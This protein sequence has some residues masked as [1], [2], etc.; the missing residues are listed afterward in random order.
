MLKDYATGRGRNRERGRKVKYKHTPETERLEADIRELN[1]FLARF[2]L[3]GGEHYGYIRVFNN[4]S[5]NKGG[6]LYS[7]GEHSYQQTARGRTPQDDHQRRAR[8][9]NRH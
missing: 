1:E 3:M 6:R 4:H 9:G 2:E 7:I 8:R 5:W